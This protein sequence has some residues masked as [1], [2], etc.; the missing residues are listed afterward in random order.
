MVVGVTNEPESLVTRTMEEVGMEFPVARVKG[1]SIDDAYGIKGFPSAFLIDPRG[2][3]AW[4]GHPGNLDESLIERQFGSVVYAAPLADK[5]Y[6]K[7][8]AALAKRELGKAHAAIE[9]ALA[10]IGLE[11]QGHR[12]MA[13]NVA[14]VNV[15]LNDARLRLDVPIVKVR[16][17][18]PQA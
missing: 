6:A 12:V 4:A 13:A 9:K 11:A 14:T 8:N 1:E 18:I 15:H 10:G 2:R 7:I 17:K 16:G 5:R 3:I